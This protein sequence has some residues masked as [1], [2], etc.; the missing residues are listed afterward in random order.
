MAT[1]SDRRFMLRALALARLGVGGAS[2]NPSVGCVVVKGESIVGEAFHVYSEREHA[3]VRAIRQ[4]GRKARGATAYVSLEPCSYHGRTPPCADL[5]VESG[6]RRVVLSAIDPNPRVCGKGI[7]RLRA[8]G[9]EV[10]IGLMQKTA[11][12]II[13]PFACYIRTGRPLVVSKVGMSLDGRIAAPK[14]RS[15]WLSSEEARR[16]GQT[17][18]HE[19]DA[20]LVGIGTILDDD[21]QLTYR[22][23]KQKVRPLIRVLLDSRLRT[24]PSAR[25]FNADP[26]QPVII[27]CSSGAPSARRRNLERRCAEI[28]SIPR[29]GGRL[30][31]KAVLK[32]LGRR[33]ILGV[34]VEGGSAVHWSFVS[35]QL[36]DKFYFMV[37]PLVLGGSRSI[38]AV[39]GDGYMTVPSA[40]R[41][42]IERRIQ[43]GSDL[44]LETFPLYSRSILSPWLSAEADPLSAQCCPPPSPRR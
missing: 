32:E 28:I 20:I 44:I 37:A 9:I 35:A 43:A 30:N 22:G 14:D 4:A 34:L 39:G 33:G 1:D 21:P 18:R 16:F 7:E 3:E 41:F 27:F 15:H 10:E 38:P 8:A 2:P 42:K 31:L 26:P 17:L 11:H 23:R 19:L 5:L 25:I 6:I 24:P 36:V 12:R 40:P 13:E 29:A